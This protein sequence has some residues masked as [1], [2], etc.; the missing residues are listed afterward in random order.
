MNQAIIDKWNKRIASESNIEGLYMAIGAST[1]RSETIEELLPYLPTEQA[2]E[3]QKVKQGAD[4][5]LAAC[6]KELASRQNS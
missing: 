6:R 1:A 2:T 5:H 3:W 4:A